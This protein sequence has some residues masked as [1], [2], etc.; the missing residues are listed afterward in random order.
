MGG[1]VTIEK[2]LHGEIKREQHFC[3]ALADSDKKWD[4]DTNVGDTAQ[5][6]L[7]LMK[8]ENPFN[9]KLYVMS[10]V[11]EI[12]NLIPR[13]FVEKFGDKTGFIDIFNYKIG[14]TNNITEF[15]LQGVLL[16][17]I[18]VLCSDFIKTR[19]NRSDFPPLRDLPDPF[20]AAVFHFTHSLHH[21]FRIQKLD[22]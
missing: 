22:S 7:D 12:E 9:C 1:G 3:L 19:A 5:K 21:T 17:T 6:M 4:G 20:N 18:S 14:F 15:E 10:K 2:V 8:N 16:L 13:K 11:R